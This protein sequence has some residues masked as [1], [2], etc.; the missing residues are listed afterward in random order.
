MYL[1]KSPVHSIRLNEPAVFIPS[2]AVGLRLYSDNRPRNLEIAPLQKGLVMLFQ[3]TELIEEG[4]GFG[5][6]IAKYDDNT[7]FS[8]T[9]QIYLENQCDGAVVLRKVFFLD[10]V[11]KKQLHGASVNDTFY[12]AL[13]AIFERAYLRR[14]TFRPVFDWTMRLRK[15]LGIATQFEKV[16]PRGKV[17]VT[18]SCLPGIVRVSVDL[19]ALDKAGAKEILV[20][21]E[22]GASAFRKYSDS[23]GT[24]LFDGQIG[25]WARV[26]AKKAVFS[27][28]YRRLS[29][30]LENKSNALFIRGREQIQD[31]F[32]W[33]GLT[34]ALSPKVSNFEY[35]ISFEK[36]Y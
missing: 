17:M 14:Q 12:S 30:S 1:G 27:D 29:F 25:A 33:A 15:T 20:L 18:Y 23:D 26:T 3:G 4:A 6:P 28:T 19:S 9:A 21:N 7:F 2:G 16:N 35:T 11:S 13:H 31:R 32:S 10:A 36:N 22:Q 5:V 34:Y 24:V 8:I